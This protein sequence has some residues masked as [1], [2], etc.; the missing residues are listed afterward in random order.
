[1]EVTCRDGQTVITD[2]LELSDPFKSRVIAQMVAAATCH[3]VCPRDCALMKRPYSDEYKHLY[4]S[5][6]M[7]TLRDNGI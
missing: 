3:N 4:F 1:M 5:S 6:L 7:R 2:N